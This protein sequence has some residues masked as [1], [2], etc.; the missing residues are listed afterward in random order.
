MKKR[1]RRALAAGLVLCLCLPAALAAA[2]AA[3]VAAL[4]IKAHETPA[5][6]DAYAVIALARGGYETPKGWYEA[7]DAALGKALAAN[8]GLP[9]K[10]D[11]A[12]LGRAV[13]AR[14]ARGQSA[15]DLLKPFA[16]LEKVAAAG[17]DDLAFALLALDSAGYD[18][19]A[20]DQ[21]KTPATRQ[22]YVDKL[23]SLQLSGGSF[24]AQSGKSPEIMATVLAV[25]ALAAYRAQ[26]AVKKALDAAMERLS[27]MQG[28]DGAF[29]R[30]PAT[31][32]QMVIALGAMQVS[33]YDERFVKGGNTLL[34][35]LLLYQTK[36]G[37]F[38]KLENERESDK[39]VTAVAL[40][41]LVSADRAQAG[42]AGLYQMTDAASGT[43]VRNEDVRVPEVTQ[44][45]KTFPDLAAHRSKNAVEALAAR[46]IIDG[47]DGG[48]F[49]PDRLMTR[50]EFAAVVVRAL[51]LPLRA[52]TV[53][54]DVA[55]TAW[56]ADDVGTAWRYAIVSGVSARAFDPEGFIT[57]QQ[58]AAMLTRAARLG[59]MDTDVTAQQVSQTLSEFADGAAVAPWAAESLVFCY[60]SGIYDD[61][62][63]LVEPERA[64][65]RGEIAQAVY[66]L[67]RQAE[68]LV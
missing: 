46:A 38:A 59:G 3:S 68:L 31:T 50:A 58:A 22:D 51:G 10:G 20:S 36:D 24:P 63:A 33:L 23:L 56:Y 45:G 37:G 55:R 43:A 18:M 57:R 48:I 4:V 41:A 14:T 64:I 25:Q 27:D 17:T 9:A 26:P 6:E 67:L 65:T 15:Y 40:C 13:L 53:F 12:A 5:A 39:A 8:D 2:D 66:N 61:S 54:D 32:A 62:R 11:Y 21:V 35:A 19:P 1:F 60:R 34:D 7:Y 52:T 28:D 49:A 47:T 29:S 30:A 44:A 42:R 16:D